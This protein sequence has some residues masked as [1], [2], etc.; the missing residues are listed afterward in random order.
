MFTSPSEITSVV[1]YCHQMNTFTKI[2]AYVYFM[3]TYCV[4]NILEI[5]FEFISNTV[6]INYC[7]FM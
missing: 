4:S 6:I 2:G 5:A 1:S 7:T 3:S